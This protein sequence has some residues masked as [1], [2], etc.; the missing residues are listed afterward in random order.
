LRLD[1]VALADGLRRPSLN[2][3]QNASRLGFGGGGTH[4]GDLFVEA[5]GDVGNDTELA[6]DEHELSA[7]VHLVFL[8]AEEAFEA[9][10]GGFAVGLGDGFC[11]DFRGESVEPGSKLFALVAEEIEDF[12]FGTGLVLFGFHTVDQ[13][14]EV[15]VHESGHALGLVH[16]FPDASG[17]GNVREHLCDR[18]AIRSGDEIIFGFGKVLGN[19]NCVFAYRAK[20][21]G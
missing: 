5:A 3:T 1:R 12:G 9:G 6:L 2:T 21:S 20:G 17:D 16:F 10:L 4:L 19:L 18:A 15:V 11:E 14:E 8:G 7:V 13:G